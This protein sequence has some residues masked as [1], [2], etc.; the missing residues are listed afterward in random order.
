LVLAAALAGAEDEARLVAHATE[1]ARLPTGDKPDP[2]DIADELW[3]TGQRAVA[4]R[5]ATASG[6]RALRDFFAN[7]KGDPTAR[8]AFRDAQTAK[9][10]FRR[11]NEA[12]RATITNDPLLKARAYY[13]QGLVQLDLRRLGRAAIAFRTAAELADKVGWVTGAARGYRSASRMAGLGPAAARRRVELERKLGRPR[14][15]MDATGALGRALERDRKWAEA[16][17]VL[18]DAYERARKLKD[19]ARMAEW[20]RIRARC[21]VGRDEVAAARGCLE[22]ALVHARA[23]RDRAEEARALAELAPVYERLGELRKVLDTGARAL[24]FKR[25]LGDRRGIG[26]ALMS[27]G[28]AHLEVG[29]YAE[30]LELLEQGAD[31]LRR[32]GVS[33]RYDP[34]DALV[35]LHDAHLLV[36]NYGRAM[37]CA[38]RWAGRMGIRHDPGVSLERDVMVTHILARRGDAP[39]EML[40]IMCKA[41]RDQPALAARVLGDRAGMFERSGRLGRALADRRAAFEAARRANDRDAMARALVA[42][43]DLLLRMDRRKEAA[44]A[45][46]QAYAFAKLLG[47]REAVALS[48]RGLARA[49]DDALSAQSRAREAVGMLRSLSTRESFR[50]VFEV[51]IRASVDLDDAAGLAYFL[52]TMRGA[53]PPSVRAFLRDPAVPEPLRLEEAAALDA[54]QRALARGKQGKD[55]VAAARERLDAVHARI[56]REAPAAAEML[57]LGADTLD[58]LRGTLEPHEALILLG[59]FEQAVALVV[60]RAGARI[61]PLGPVGRLNAAAQ[62]PG[63]LLRQPRGLR[64]ASPFSDDAAQ[65]LRSLVAGPLRLDPA[66]TRLLVSPHAALA[67]VPFTLLFPGREIVYVPSG[68]A[69]RLLRKR[70]PGGGGILALG[71]PAHGER[72]GPRLPGAAEEARV[73][74][75]VV[76]T[77]AAATEPALHAAIAKR[78]HWR[79]IHFA[80]HAMVDPQRPLESAL[81]LAGGDLTARDVCRARFPADLVVLSA[82][83]TGKGRVVKA[84]GIVG[85]VRAFLFAGAPRVLVSLWKVDDLATQALMVKFHELWK[86]GQPAATALKRAQEHVAAQ[87]GWS[88]PYYWAAW[89][90]WG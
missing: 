79:A 47:T 65:K 18:D 38:E 66:L 87:K 82:C 14:Q 24:A 55:D 62:A 31:A 5:Y 63:S 13:L 21:H 26:Q 76:L 59:E 80:C 73:V 81:G 37:E 29:R 50:D 71:D 44:D 36:G 27:L 89:Q 77:G 12:K 88:D 72:W 11:L 49:H 41:T 60:T 3:G 35:E 17:R 68:T 32:E 57:Y 67:G 90:L 84:A 69:L 61:V 33:E 2:W 15:L 64:P 20:I 43:G 46:R 39:M 85:F 54:E 42:Q 8:L 40:D 1:R 25:E 19:E 51:G 9:G 48:L 28:R 7:R 52:E 6:D 22:R 23:A 30:A 78:P 4:R 10:R 58:T 75:D 86:S 16:S 83:D 56:R 34:L 70:K 45:H 53:A 74:G